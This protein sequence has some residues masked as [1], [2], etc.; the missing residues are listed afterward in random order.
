MDW[1]L[2][3]INPDGS[4]D[5]APV[6]AQ[7]L[8]IEDIEFDQ[9]NLAADTW[10]FTA[11]GREIDA[12]E[13]FPYGQLISI[14]D[15]NENRVAFGRIEPWTRQGTPDAQNHRGRL[16]NPWWYLTRLTYQQRYSVTTGNYPS[17]PPASTPPTYEVFT[18]PRVILNILFDGK[19]GWY[20]ATTGQQ[21]ADGINWAISKGAPIQLGTVDPSTQPFSDFKKGIMVSDV[22]IAQW[23]KEPD[24]IVDWDYSTKPFPTIHFRKQLTPLI[25]D[26]T[27]TLRREQVEI[28]ERPDWQYSYVRFT[29]DQ[30]NQQDGATFISIVVDTWPDPPPDGVEDRFGGVDLYCDLTGGAQ[31]STSSQAALASVP[32][33]ITDP[34]TW[35]RW[36]PDLAAGTVAA[37][38][39]LSG[40]SAPAADAARPA[41]F[42]APRDEFNPENPLASLRAH[43]PT[44][45]C[46]TAQIVPPDRR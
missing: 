3:K 33:D 31:N 26:L 39:I 35:L 17:F 40:H 4:E 41:P 16:V 36:K 22:I 37:F 21:I 24:F 6:T 11:G 44:W 27:D 23:H 1:Y 10:T 12:A 46:I 25:I 43:P 9:G 2:Q 15:V 13:L 7:S 18:S 30:S 28:R 42:V 38:T 34:N 14:Q 5:G 8:G 29:Y 45:A 19:T 20:S 32:L